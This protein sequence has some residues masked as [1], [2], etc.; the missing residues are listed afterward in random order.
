MNFYYEY[1]DDFPTINVKLTTNPNNENSIN[2]T[3]HD[4]QIEIIDKKKTTAFVNIYL[5][6]RSECF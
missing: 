2:I 3:H 1:L 6:V 5:V 4:N